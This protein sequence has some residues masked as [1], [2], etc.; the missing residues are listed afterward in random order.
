MLSPFIA[1]LVDTAGIS[2]SAANQVTSLLNVHLP[3]IAHH[4]DAISDIGIMNSYFASTTLSDNTKAA[5]MS[6]WKKVAPALRSVGMTPEKVST[7]LKQ[8]PSRRGRPRSSSAT[9][10][11][12]QTR[13]DLSNI[14]NLYY[15]LLKQQAPW[16]VLATSKWSDIS[17][18]ADG[19]VV[20]LV[21]DAFHGVTLTDAWDDLAAIFN[22]LYPHLPF[23][24]N[25]LNLTPTPIFQNLK[26][27]PLTPKAIRRMVT[28]ARTA[29]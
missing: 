19:T 7:I 1:T 20:I 3:H 22:T 25:T 4:P 23:N 18:K 9:L 24:Q 13:P 29:Q 5:Y 12:G 26:M 14:Y 28:I 8:N 15:S 17:L 27:A 16:D 6:L 10:P 21:N 2:P 11:P